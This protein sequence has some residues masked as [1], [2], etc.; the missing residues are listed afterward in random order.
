V[1]RSRI[2]ALGI[3]A[4]L[5]Q[6]ALWHGPLGAADRLA[7]K[8]ETAAAAEIKHQEMFGVTA[9]L[10]RSPLRRR[11]VLTG[12]SDKFQQDGLARLIDDIPGVAGT[13]WATRP[14]APVRSVP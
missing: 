5:A 4:V 10:E 3:A 2:I 7:D 12:P 11:M 8:L 13:R 6:T 9:R 1:T 14:G